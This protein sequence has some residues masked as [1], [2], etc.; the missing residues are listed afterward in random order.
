MLVSA[1]PSDLCAVCDR[2]LVAEQG[3]GLVDASTR[4]PDAL[5]ENL[6]AVRPDHASEQENRKVALTHG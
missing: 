6:Y 4:D 5:L 3:G 2:I 1:E